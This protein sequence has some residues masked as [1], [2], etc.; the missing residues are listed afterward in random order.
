[1]PEVRGSHIGFTW[2]REIRFPLH[3][4]LQNGSIRFQEIVNPNRLASKKLLN[5]PGRK[6][7]PVDSDHLGRRPEGFRQSNEIAIC[8]DHCR[9]L[10]S[11][12]PIENK[13]IG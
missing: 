4:Q 10:S 2:N 11:P 6:I 7:T 1:V 12:G 9:N 3:A 13:G 8:A 5:H